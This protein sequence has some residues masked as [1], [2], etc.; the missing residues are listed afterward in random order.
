MIRILL[1]DDHAIVREGYRTLLE[2]QGMHI[3]AEAADG[4]EA[5]RLYKETAPDLVIMDLAMPGIGG[6]EA[7][8]RIRQRDPGARILA[9][10][11]HRNPSFAIQAFQA[12]ALGY[13]T[14]S[15]APEILLNAVRAVLQGRRALSPDISE[16]LALDRL[17]G[18][19]GAFDALSPREFEILRLLLDGKNQAEIASTLHIAPKTVAN[20]HYI[21]K[22]KL[23][24]GSDIELMRLALQAGIFEA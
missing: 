17:G 24:V 8:R 18:E 11:M 6:I 16:D 20:C 13:V 10:T 1:A 9:F 23:G 2:K 7:I 5:Y 4:A 19:A 21:I 22:G 3:V 14:K 12:G 15:S